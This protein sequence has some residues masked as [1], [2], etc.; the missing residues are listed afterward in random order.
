MEVQIITNTDKF[1]KNKQSDIGTSFQ[2]RKKI[3]GNKSCISSDNFEI[4]KGK[5]IK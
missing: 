2:G 4:E 3:R 1:I 5:I